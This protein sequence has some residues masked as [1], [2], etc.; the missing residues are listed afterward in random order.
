M[1]VNT[2]SSGFHFFRFMSS[3]LCTKNCRVRNNGEFTLGQ[4]DQTWCSNYY[5]EIN[6]FQIFGWF[7]FWFLFFKY[8]TE[9]Y[10]NTRYDFAANVKVFDTIQT[11]AFNWLPWLLWP[12]SRS[13]QPS[14][15][16]NGSNA[17]HI[18]SL[19]P[20]VPISFLLILHISCCPPQ[21]CTPPSPSPFCCKKSTFFSTLH[22]GS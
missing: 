18:P 22:L 12:S 19:L 15:L 6:M 7:F 11:L 2:T 3:A 20:V 5:F 10:L 13:L 9:Q 14:W 21:S 4:M 17:F 1:H 16:Y 8:P